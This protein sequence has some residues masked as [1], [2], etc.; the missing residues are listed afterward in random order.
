[1]CAIYEFKGRASK[2]GQE[3]TARDESGLIQKVWAGFARNEILEWWRRKGGV[4]L[5]IFAS[6]FAE[7]SDLNRKLIWDDVPEG[8]VIRGLLVKDGVH[9]LIK[10]VTRA[11]TPEEFARFEHPRMPVLE[12]P[13]YGAIP[14]DLPASAQAELF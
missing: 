14:A 8:Q 1:M 2:P 10:V 6:R 13:L 11:S 9:P 12:P 5:D 7:R 3:I 4:E